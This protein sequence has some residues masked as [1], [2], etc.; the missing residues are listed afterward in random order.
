MR[1]TYKYATLLRPPQ[2]GACPMTDLIS[3]SCEEGVA[4]SA[5][6][7]WGWVKYYR[8]LTDK[9]VSDYELEFVEEGVCPE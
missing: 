1:K 7:I 5:H 3:V 8:R 4:P 6:L 2:L 9:E